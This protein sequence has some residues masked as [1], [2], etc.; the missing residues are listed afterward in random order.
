MVQVQSPAQEFSHAAGMVNEGK[1]R[2]RERQEER[3]G[4]KKKREERKS[5][6]EACKAVFRVRK[7][8][9]SLREAVSQQGQ[10][11]R[12]CYL[13]PLLLAVPSFL[14]RGRVFG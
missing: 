2:K 4:E 8:G 9:L 6:K 1:E 7:G 10:K 3:R 12:H 11:S 5:K 13:A 14:P